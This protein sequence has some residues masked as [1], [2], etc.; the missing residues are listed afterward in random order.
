MIREQ[1]KQHG[2]VFRNHTSVYD[3]CEVLVYYDRLAA[4]ENH[5][6][7]IIIFRDAGTQH[8]WLACLGTMVVVGAPVLFTVPFANRL[9]GSP[10]EYRSRL[11]SSS[12]PNPDSWHCHWDTK[13]IYG[14]V[15]YCP[16]CLSKTRVYAHVFGIY[17]RSIVKT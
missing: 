10:G 12:S 11:R 9:T 2:Q 4:K 13:D 5:Q 7:G 15:V 14:C 17:R 3:A 6:P 1:D 8:R 16:Y